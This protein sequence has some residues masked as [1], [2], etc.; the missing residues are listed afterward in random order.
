M[1]EELY[2]V[3]LD[4]QAILSDGH[5]VSLSQNG[6]VLAIDAEAAILDTLVIFRDEREKR[7]DIVK[8]WG[9]K[10]DIS[11]VSDTARRDLEALLQGVPDPASKFTGHTDKN[12]API[13]DGDQVDDGHSVYAVHWDAKG[14]KWTLV[15]VSGAYRYPPFHQVR[16]M[17]KVP[18]S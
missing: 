12:G 10:V 15:R 2:R 13:H 11:L 7:P 6:E 14:G 17:V 9:M 3:R 18:P 8:V 1:S 4:Y 5:A 16:A